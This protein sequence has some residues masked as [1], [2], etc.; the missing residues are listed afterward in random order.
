MARVQREQSLQR[1]ICEYLALAAPPGFCFF[2]I[3]LGGGGRKRGAILK[4]TGSK[5]GVP[6][7]ITLYG[8]VARFLEVKAKNGRL[9]AIQRERH[10]ELIDAG[11]HIAIVRSVE[12]TQETLLHWGVPI[13]ARVTGHAIQRDTP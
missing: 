7:L 11:C 2:A 8:G 13:R 3:P 12:E 1:A 10:A 6:D 9:S 4:T 5:A